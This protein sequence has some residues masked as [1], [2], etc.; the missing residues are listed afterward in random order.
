MGLLSKV[1]QEL[2][3]KK[4]VKRFHLLISL[5]ICVVITGDDPVTS[6]IGIGTL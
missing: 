1:R 5:I 3:N 2:G 6:P 4:G